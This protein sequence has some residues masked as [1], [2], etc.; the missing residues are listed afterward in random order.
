MW[1]EFVELQK[2]LTATFTFFAE[3]PKVDH[4]P[5][6]GHY[7]FYWKNARLDMGHISVVDKR[8]E[9]GVWMMHVNAY[10]RAQYPMPVY[11]FDVVCGKNKVTGCFHDISPTGYNDFEVANGYEE[12]KRRE[13][14]DWAK[15]IF[16]EGM[17]AA[18][19]VNEEKEINELIAI[20]AS[21]LMTWF[22][23]QEGLEMSIPDYNYMNALSKYCQ[24]Q[25]MNPHSFAVMMK[26]GFPEEYL[27][28]FK[29][30]KQ[31][32]Y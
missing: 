1:N 10:S 6:L 32:P 26:L 27:R 13:L 4:R 16:S 8:E 20:G 19:N 18:G 11:G 31:F 14:P 2:E 12:S 22:E 3:N 21:N 29:M 17:V 28:N 23:V 7:N 30:N 25:L 15:E 5:D 9:K 24:N